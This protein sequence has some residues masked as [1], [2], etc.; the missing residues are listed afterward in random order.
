MERA[1]LAQ[2]C[3]GNPVVQSVLRALADVGSGGPGRDGP[4]QAR[5][6]DLL[7]LG[8]PAPSRLSDLGGPLWLGLF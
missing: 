3:E 7:L 1:V 8:L 6:S 5:D 2:L 4:I